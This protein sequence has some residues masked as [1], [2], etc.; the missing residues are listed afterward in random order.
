MDQRSNE[1]QNG[2]EQIMHPFDHPSETATI[3]ENNLDDWA[4]SIDH[5]YLSV[6]QGKRVLEIASYNGTIARR[7]LQHDP[8]SLVMVEP[9]CIPDVP[10]SDNIKHVSSDINLWLSEPRPVD[11][12]ICFGLLYHLHNSLHLTEL[13]VNYCNPETIVFDS[14]VAPHPLAFNREINNTAG[15]RQTTEQWKYAPFN[16]IT[17]FFIINNSLDHM[18]YDLVKSH[19]LRC[20]ELSK[21]NSWVAEWRKKR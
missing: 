8:L 9:Y 5:N 13:I 12:V 3:A 21:S 15:M 19:H 20:N 4:D 1:T 18:G 14:V 2:S 10:L 11:V 17:P 7:I 16:L 6:C